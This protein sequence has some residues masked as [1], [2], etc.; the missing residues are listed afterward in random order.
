MYVLTDVS[1]VT[2][3][4]TSQVVLS[5]NTVTLIAFTDIEGN[6]LPNVTWTAPDNRLITPSSHFNTSID[7]QITITNVTNEDN[8]TY[9]CIVNNGIGSGLYQAVQLIIAGICIAVIINYDTLSY[10]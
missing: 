2:R 6:P 4:G 9:T 1:T 7:G 3:D 8:G 5:G 10:Q